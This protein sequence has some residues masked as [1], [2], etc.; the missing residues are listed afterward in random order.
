VKFTVG[1]DL[2]THLHICPAIFSVK[3]MHLDCS[4][5]INIISN[6]TGLH[7]IYVMFTYLGLQV[8]QVTS[9]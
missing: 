3:N 9:E 1:C 8:M 7:K 6:K 5:L 4:F 2:V